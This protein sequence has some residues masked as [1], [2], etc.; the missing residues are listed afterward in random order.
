MFPN[1]ALT[2]LAMAHATAVTHNY[3]PRATREESRG[4]LFSESCYAPACGRHVTLHS[5][6]VSKKQLSAAPL[7]ITF[8]DHVSVGVG[9]VVRSKLV[10]TSSRFS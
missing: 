8:S 10:Q 1:P 5:A 4:I 6:R 2:S 7:F 3:I 9:G